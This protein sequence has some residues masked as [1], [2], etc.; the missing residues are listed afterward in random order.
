MNDSIDVDLSR[1]SLPPI[2]EACGPDD[3][4]IR[5]SCPFTSLYRRLRAA[6]QAQDTLKDA[7]KPADLAL[8]AIGIGALLAASAA[9]FGV[10]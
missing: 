8:C 5:F 1:K 9:Y 4:K 3:T 2:V 6:W 10:I 7:Q